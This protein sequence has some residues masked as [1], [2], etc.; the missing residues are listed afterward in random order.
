MSVYDDYEPPVSEG[1]YH[2]FENGHTY[3]FR[4]AS[5]PVAYISSFVNKGDGEISDR[6]MYAWLAWNFETKSVQILKLP[7]TA[8][9]QVMKFARDTEYGDPTKYNFRIT[10]NGEALKTVYDV[11]ASPNKSELAEIAPE[12]TEKLLE[13]DL[14]EAVSKGKGV[15]NVNWL[16]DIAKKEDGSATKP[17]KT[18][19]PEQNQNTVVDE[20]KGAEAP[21]DEPW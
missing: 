5:E 16:R 21:G 11:I 4:L 3:Q 15:S 18:A 9:K 14:I 6:M 1:L 20:K 12:S 7:V 8:F 17:E 10:R 19:D 13:V 2:K